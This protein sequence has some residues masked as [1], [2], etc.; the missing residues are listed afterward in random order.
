MPLETPA[1]WEPARPPPHPPSQRV[2]KP[3]RSATRRRDPSTGEG[4]RLLRNKL[5]R[6]ITGAAVLALTATGAITGTANA[7]THVPDT[8]VAITGTANATTDAADN[9]SADAADSTS[10]DL[11]D[12]ISAAV[13]DAVWT[14]SGWPAPSADPHLPDANGNIAADQ[15]EEPQPLIDEGIYGPDADPASTSADSADSAAA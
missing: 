1:N 3:H 7:T 12:S 8:T 5:G 6:T 2:P 10:I 11:P 9:A 15:E 14:A 4:T 13:P